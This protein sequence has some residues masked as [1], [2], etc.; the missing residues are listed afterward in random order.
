MNETAA[1]PQRT[2]V[3]AAGKFKG[4][5]ALTIGGDSGIGCAVAVPDAQQ[6]A[7]VAIAYF[8]EQE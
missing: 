8:W 7:N 3:K 1:N 4:R 6:A 2:K 5:V